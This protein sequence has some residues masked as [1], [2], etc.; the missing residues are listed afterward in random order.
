V[1]DVTRYGSTS[2]I[3]VLDS[4]A[5]N[6]AQ[7]RITRWIV[8]NRFRPRVIDGQVVDASRIVARAY[9]QE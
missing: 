3:R 4:N 7:S 5:S 9:V 6:A 1:F 2:R 8:A